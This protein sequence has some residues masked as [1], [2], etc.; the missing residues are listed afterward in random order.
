[1]ANQGVFQTELK[2]FSAHRAAWALAHP[3]EY[4][5]IRRTEVVGF[6]PTFDKALEAAL[7]KYAIGEC[8]V[9]QIFDR[10]PVY[11]IF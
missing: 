9:K 2:V 10:D 6:Y 11:A 4:V 7:S 3:Q 5:V 1:M 8:L